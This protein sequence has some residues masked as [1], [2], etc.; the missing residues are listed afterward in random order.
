M[1]SMNLIGRLG[2]DAEVKEYNGKKVIHFSVA[3]DT[4]YGDK[5]QTQWVHVSK[6]GENTKVAD[7]LK[8]GTQVY[9]SGEPSLYTSEVGTT[10]LKLSC[11]NLTLVGGREAAPAPDAPL[12]HLQN[13][14]A[15]EPVDDLPF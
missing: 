1:I 10:Y 12:A 4:G 5:K 3:V 9:V 7:Y 14:P 2:R 8:K 15:I 6:W 13:Q 11:S